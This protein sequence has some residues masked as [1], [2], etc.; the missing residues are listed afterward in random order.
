MTATRLILERQWL[1]ALLLLLL[2][3]GT[4]WAS[5]IEGFATGQLW[6]VN[7]TTWC[8]LAITTAVLHQVYVWII[9]RVQLHT[10]W[11]TK[12]MGA[13]GF[14]LY[15]IGFSILGILRVVLV[16]LLAISNRGALPGEPVALQ[17]LGAA[18]LL[19][20]L[21]LFYSVHRYFG[22][23]R[24]FGI[25]HFDASYRSMPFV[26]RG[27]FRWTSN[28]MYVFG[29]LVLWAPALWF[30]SPAALVAALFNHLYIWVH[31]LSTEL[32]DMRRIYG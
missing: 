19:P 21:Y 12:T 13:A 2:L 29:F 18:A 16:V 23:R 5:G 22:F 11:I 10:G 20:A 9:W 31:Y 8:K 3:A 14:T 27:I 32:P 1:H 28:G 24:A 25:D 30:A 26:R 17:V 15:A 7:S 4:F 6:G